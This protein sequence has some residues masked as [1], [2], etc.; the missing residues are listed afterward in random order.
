MAKSAPFSIRLSPR[1]HSLI[2]KEAK[3]TRRSKGAIIER[4]ADEAL[5]C[6]RFPGIAFREEDPNRR[7]WVV[8]TALD[9]WEIIQALEDFG[10]SVARMAAESD[11]D[12]HQI[13][14]AA[15]Y[16][17]EYPEEID[18]FVAENRRPIEELRQLYPNIDVRIVD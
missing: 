18:Q 4:L 17:K 7:A 12:E 6:Q 11:L 3:R 8:G 1:L 10:W 14:L 13:E 9:V 2:A 16:Y 15:A 5:R